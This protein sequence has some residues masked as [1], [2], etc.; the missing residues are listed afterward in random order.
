VLD[1]PPSP[2]ERTEL[3]FEAASAGPVTVVVEAVTNEEPVRAGEA[4]SPF[5]AYQIVDMLLDSFRWSR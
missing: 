5:P 2:S 1:E 3:A 4:S